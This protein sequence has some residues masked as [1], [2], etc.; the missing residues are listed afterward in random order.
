MKALLVIILFLSTS[1]IYPTHPQAMMMP[2]S[3]VLEPIDEKLAN[4]K[5]AALIYKVQLRPPSSAR[6]NV[7]ILSVHLPPPSAY[8]E[9]DAYEGFAFI[10]GVI[11][12]QFMLDPTQEESP[13]WAG[14]FDEITA[15][16]ENVKVQVR[17]F[18][19]KTA[20]LGPAILGNDIKNC[21]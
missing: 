15:E 21:H 5:G 11:S 13:T 9:Y 7:S 10:P 19:S 12:W 14:R 1:V 17:L 2:C 4:A 6:T 18:N 16:M 20:K 8:G 3:M